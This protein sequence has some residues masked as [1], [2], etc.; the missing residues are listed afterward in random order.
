MGVARSIDEPIA[1]RRRWRLP[2]R[3]PD[4]K[5]KWLTVYVIIWA[6]ML[7]L[8][9]IG[10]ARFCYAY[11]GYQS[12]PAWI[13]YGLQLMTVGDDLRVMTGLTAEARNAVMKPGERL[14]AIDDWEVPRSPTALTDARV[15]LFKPEGSSTVFKLIGDDGAVRDI[16]LTYS[17]RHIDEVFQGTGL[18]LPGAVAIT[19]GGTM[20]NCLGLVTAAVLLFM[21]QRRQAVPALLS[22]GFLIASAAAFAAQWSDLGVSYAI[23]NFVAAIGFCLLFAA[24]FALPDGRLFPRWTRVA[25]LALPLFLV[26]SVT[27]ESGNALTTATLIFCV[28]AIMALVGRYRSLPA[29]PARQQMRWVFLGF[30]AGIVLGIL[31]LAG[32]VVTDWLLPADS[33]WYAWGYIPPFLGNIGSLV[34]AA[35]LMISILK[36]RLYDADAVIGRS[37]A[38]GV[39]TLGFLALFAGSEKLVELIGE[40]YFEHS[41]GMAAGAIGAAVAAVCIVPL[42]NRIH[43]WAERRFQKPLIR[44]RE[45]LPEAVA[46][47]RESASIEQLTSAVMRRVEAGVHST[48]EALLLS[49]AGKL[50]IIGTRGISA[51]AVRTWQSSWQPRSSEEALD[52]DRK[53][54]TFPLRVRLWVETGYEPETMGWLLL[55][56][57]PDGTFFGKDERETLE[58]VAGPVGRAI[59]IA[60]TRQV[61]EAEAERR[62][63]DL[64]RV[65]QTLRDGLRSRSADPSAA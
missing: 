40:K 24:L 20:M 4:L 16:K 18:S 54:D 5:G 42:H 10:P 17:R 38:F 47:L 33:R 64:E 59:H 46:D 61:R 51:R 49:N 43:A 7:P 6:I 14:L 55:G 39:L 9:I 41:I 26:A 19:I 52:C 60:Q 29:G 63:C 37:A 13:A 28:L 44:L 21:R 53:D 3:L 45:G 8:A 50:K 58:S 2:E 15:H 1:R 25:V 32:I 27:D 48:H 30:V 12:K 23:V 65:V 56:P 22:L 36:Y 31:N 57:R 35:G 11:Y 62:L 34:I